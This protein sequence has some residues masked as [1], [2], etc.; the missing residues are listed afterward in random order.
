MQRVCECL[1]VLPHGVASLLPLH[2]QVHFELHSDPIPFFPV[3]EVV[4]AAEK[5][6]PYAYVSLLGALS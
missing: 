2:P 5:S 3:V 6:D 1:G 4:V